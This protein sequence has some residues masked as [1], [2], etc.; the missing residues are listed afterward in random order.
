MDYVYDYV[1]KEEEHIDIMDVEEAISDD[2][3]NSDYICS[4]EQARLKIKEAMERKKIHYNDLKKHIEFRNE[5]I[6]QIRKNSSLTLKQI[7]ELF[8]GI[9]E[10]RVSRVLTKGS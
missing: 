4:M 8:G 5:L 10:S 3:Y 6:S 1:Y 9:S 7:G 2:V